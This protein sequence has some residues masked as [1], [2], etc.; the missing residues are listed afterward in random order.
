MV[1]LPLDDHKTNKS[2]P[3][4]QSISLSMNYTSHWAKSSFA[5]AAIDA[6]RTQQYYIAWQ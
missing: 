2:G 4:L 3:L 5:Q 6:E 1:T